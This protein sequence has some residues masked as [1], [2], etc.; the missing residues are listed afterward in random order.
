MCYSDA[1]IL[2]KGTI[3]I[4]GEEDNG[5]AKEADERN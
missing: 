3:A 4:T 5:A 1:Y 2:A